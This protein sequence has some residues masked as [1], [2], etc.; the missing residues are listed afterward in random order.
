MSVQTQQVSL[1]MA[2]EK[3][4]A[5]ALSVAQSEQLQIGQALLVTRSASIHHQWTPLLEKA[6]K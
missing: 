5:A 4:A 2:G 3:T 1:G 6:E